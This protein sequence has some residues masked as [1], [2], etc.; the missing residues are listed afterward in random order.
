MS[1]LSGLRKFADYMSRT[2]FPADPD[3]T[4][5]EEP[6]KAE[7]REYRDEQQALRG[8]YLVVKE[9][10]RKPDAENMAEAATRPEQGQA[11]SFRRTADA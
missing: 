3:V 5:T 4:R 1:F 10:R 2:D 11:A 8:A 6:A 7:A 9:R